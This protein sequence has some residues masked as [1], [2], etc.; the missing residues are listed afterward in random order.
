MSGISSVISNVWNTIKTTVTNVLNAISS[1]VSNIWNSIKT[2]V[3]NAMNSISSTVSSIWENVKS[4]VG[5]AITN[6]KTTI[7]NGFEAA[8]NYI[9]SLPS[10]AWNWGADIINGIVNGIRA[11]ISSIKSAVSDV[12]DTI[13]SHLHFS[14]PDEGPLTDFPTWMPDMMHGLAQGIR[15]NMK[16]VKSAVSNLASAMVPDVDL[17]P[18]LAPYESDRFPLPRSPKQSPVSAGSGLYGSGGGGNTYNITM[19]V[20]QMNSD[21][22]ARRAAEV[23]AEEIERLTTDN[24]SMKGSWSV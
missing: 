20:N 11:K 23:T 5:S 10:Q 2:A 18:A 4:A 17:A 7:V 1:T 12:A 15:Q 13:K 3:S 6:I 14:V 21:Y 16:Y 24:N 9:K 8:V 19:N 22:D